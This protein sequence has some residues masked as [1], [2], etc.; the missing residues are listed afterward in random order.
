MAWTQIF[1]FFVGRRKHCR[2][3]SANNPIYSRIKSA[4]S[5]SKR[6]RKNPWEMKYPYSSLHGKEINKNDFH[7]IMTNNKVWLIS[8]CD[9]WSTTEQK[10]KFECKIIFVLLSIS[11]DV[12]ITKFNE[13][14]SDL[15]QITEINHFFRKIG[16]FISQNLKYR[17]LILDRRWHFVRSHLHN[18][19]S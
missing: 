7:R 1:F 5:K 9:I 2:G 11:F 17:I 19:F 8:N 6:K 13:M 14:P 15:W 16:Q 10:I 12:F 3:K 18:I 4:L